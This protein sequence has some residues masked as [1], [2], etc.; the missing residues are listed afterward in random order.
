MST[1]ET[2][3]AKAETCVPVIG[4]NPRHEKQMIHF[5]VKHYGWKFAEDGN[6]YSPNPKLTAKW[7]ELG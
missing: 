6:L 5:L 7:R 3:P 2:Y 4:Q 1:T